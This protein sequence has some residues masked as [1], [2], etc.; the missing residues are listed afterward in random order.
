ME[1]KKIHL[2]ILL[3]IVYS[4]ILYFLFVNNQTRIRPILSEFDR[5][6]SSE[7]LA[8]TSAERLGANT[9]IEQ[10]ETKTL[11]S[12]NEQDSSGLEDQSISNIEQ[13]IIRYDDLK[14]IQKIERNNGNL[15]LKLRK[16][17]GFSPTINASE[18][19]KDSIENELQ[20]KIYA[21]LFE[22]KGTQ[23][24]SYSTID[25]LKSLTGTL[26]IPTTGYS[27][28][29]LSG[30]LTEDKFNKWA[31]KK[32]FQEEFVKTHSKTI[33][34]SVK[35]SVFRR[36]SM[37]VTLSGTIYLVEDHFLTDLTLIQK[38]L[39][40]ISLTIPFFLLYLFLNQKGILK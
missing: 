4:I 25:T 36:M 27:A 33:V 39:V 3:I 21:K 26:S 18:F 20:S 16:L 31:I 15:G 34:N 10:G 11:N 17:K 38:I 32:G 8:N 19:L 12:Q 14:V 9:A 28:Y 22:K 1:I 30:N 6:K 29:Y 37:L 23:N 5:I 40:C 13:K 35:S 2:G 24:E 7:Q